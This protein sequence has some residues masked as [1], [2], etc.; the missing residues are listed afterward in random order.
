MKNLSELSVKA[1]ISPKNQL[2]IS[3]EKQ[4][5]LLADV[6]GKDS[7]KSTVARLTY[8]SIILNL[9]VWKFCLPR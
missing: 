1:Y 2:V 6:Y 5:I 4:I 3:A 8:I 9:A 7:T